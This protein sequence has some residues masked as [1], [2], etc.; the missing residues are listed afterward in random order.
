VVITD[1]VPSLVFC[2]TV[3]GEPTESLATCVHLIEHHIT[4]DA[5]PDR[6]VSTRETR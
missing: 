3:R 5:S 4:L 2:S 1:L 6:A